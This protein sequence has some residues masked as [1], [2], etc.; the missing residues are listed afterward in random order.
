MRISFVG[1][2]CGCGGGG[3]GGGGGALLPAA[4]LLTLPSFL[5]GIPRCASQL[6]GLFCRAQPDS[7]PPNGPGFATFGRVTNPGGLATARVANAGSAI[8]KQK[9]NILLVI[10]VGDHW[11]VVL[12]H[13]PATLVGVAILL[14][15]AGAGVSAF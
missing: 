2:G 15:S 13:P 9:K 5:F 11:A 3:G 6:R 10:I 8:F 12:L 14:T 7:N 4:A 1:G